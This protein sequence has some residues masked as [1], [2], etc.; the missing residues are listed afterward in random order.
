MALGLL[1]VMVSAAAAQQPILEVRLPGVGEILVQARLTE[2]G[3]LELPVEPLEELT[4]EEFGGMDFLS[5]PAL[6]SH[7]GPGILVDYDSS[8]ALVRIRDSA[9]RLAATRASYDRRR[10]ESRVRPDGFLI[11]GPYGS[12][13]TEFGGGSLVDGGW[14]FG[15][16]AVGGSHSTESGSRWNV[17]VEPYR[18]TFLTYQDGD[19]YGPRFGLR[20]VGGPTFFEATYSPDEGDWSARAATS[21]GPWTFYLQEDGAASISHT[22]TVQVTL[23]RTADGIVTRLSYGRYPSPLSVPRLR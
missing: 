4:G 11:G 5:I 15:R 16:F 20:W 7:L 14:N 1:L 13:T 17:S 6:Q 19:R 21:A 10:A 18:R 3:I 12:L 2:D 8:R 22:S 9:G 23:G